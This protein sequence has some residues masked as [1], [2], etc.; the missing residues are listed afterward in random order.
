MTKISKEEMISVIYKKIADKT[1]NQWCKIKHIDWEIDTINNQIWQSD[2]YYVSN[3]NWF[4]ETYS[5]EIDEIIWHPVRIWDILD[6]KLRD[7]FIIEKNIN[8]QWYII[9]DEAKTTLEIINLWE[10]KRKPIDKQS[11]KC[12][13]YIYNLIK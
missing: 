7:K 6:Y 1:L 9:Y 10:E 4:G 11:K 12:I 5:N 2:A 8:Y 3:K 13:K